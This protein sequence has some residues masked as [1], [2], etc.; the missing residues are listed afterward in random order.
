MRYDR[1]ALEKFDPVTKKYVADDDRARDWYA[2]ADVDAAGV[3]RWKSNGSVPFPD[4]LQQ[5]AGLGLR[6]NVEASNAAKS[7]DL[8]KMVAEMKANPPPPPDAEQ[9]FEMRAAFGR[10]TTVVNVF[11]GRKIAKL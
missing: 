2:K 10:G 1:P 4:M 6:V 11:T 8:D 9:M 5:W 3:A 7:A